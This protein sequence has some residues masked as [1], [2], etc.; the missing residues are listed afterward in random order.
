MGGVTLVTITVLNDT[1]D[2]AHDLTVS[3]P[4][5]AG[6]AVVSKGNLVWQQAV[7]AGHSQAQFTTQLQVTQ[8]PADGAIL[9]QPQVLSRETTT[10]LT[11]VAGVLI[12]SPISSTLAQ[13]TPR[14]GQHA[15]LC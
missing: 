2:V 10:P 13:Y 12:D 7:L 4:L 5:P 8:A 9:L 14:L 1:P 15:A 6:V 3:L 11:N